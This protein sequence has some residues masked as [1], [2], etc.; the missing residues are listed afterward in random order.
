M[1]LDDDNEA[2]FWQEAARR[3][4]HVER[5]PA[6][7][8]FATASRLAEHLPP[9]GA[10]EGATAWL[11][12]VGQ[13]DAATA[14]SAANDG[15]TVVALF[16][17]PTSATPRVLA[18]L[19]RRAA[20][21]DTD[22]LPLPP[23]D[24]PLESDDGRLRLIVR[25]LDGGQLRLRLSAQGLAADDLANRAVG[26]LI[27]DGTHAGEALV[28]DLDD[29]GDAERVVPDNTTVRQLLLRPVF[30]DMVGEDTP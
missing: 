8:S 25:R 6:I 17:R 20:A 24:V 22:T 21:S 1:S 5:E 4:H 26:L 14:P 30:I 7:D 16:R 9:R 29:D 15:A 27:E 19:S 3:L 13:S 18:A 23:D 11:R 2:L 10:D 28:F 12:R